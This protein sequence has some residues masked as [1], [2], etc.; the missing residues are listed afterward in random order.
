MAIHVSSI[1]VDLTLV[2][3]VV[4]ASETARLPSA[5]AYEDLLAIVA[6][7]TFAILIRVAT[8]ELVPRFRASLDINVGANMATPVLIANTI[9]AIPI[10]AKMEGRA[11]RLQACRGIN[12]VARPDGMEILARILSRLAMRVF[13]THA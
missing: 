10:L 8:V 1:N 3:T 4:F 12:A 13:L 5:F 6:K 9:L 11:P 2:C 7:T